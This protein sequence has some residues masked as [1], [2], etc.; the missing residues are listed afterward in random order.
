[1]TLES[2]IAHR[3]AAHAAAELCVE[4]INETLKEL[5]AAHTIDALPAFFATLRHV[6]GKNLAV[7]A[8]QPIAEPPQV[9]TRPQGNDVDA[10][11]ESIDESLQ[12]VDEVPERGQDFAESVAGKLR[13]IANKIEESDEVTPGQVQ[14]IENM[15]GGLER[16]TR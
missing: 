6:Y 2:N 5:V 7:A 14:A 12:L 13:S 16:W 4:F 3:K 11:L 10:A 8:E 15:R 9:P 1:M